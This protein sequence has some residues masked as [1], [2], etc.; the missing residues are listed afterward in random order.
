[1]KTLELEKLCEKSEKTD[2]AISTIKHCLAP[3]KR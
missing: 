2:V 1:M 3:N